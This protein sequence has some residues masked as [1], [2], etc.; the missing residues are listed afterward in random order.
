MN[1]KKWFD[2]HYFA[3]IFWLLCFLILFVTLV[4]MY[5]GCTQGWLDCTMTNT[6]NGGI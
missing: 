6:T 5:F 2:K 1:F 3:I 4:V